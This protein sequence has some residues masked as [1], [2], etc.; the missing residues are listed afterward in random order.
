MRTWKIKVRYITSI[1]FTFSL[2]KQK[3]ELHADK[4]KRK[5]ETKTSSSYM[6]AH[7]CAPV[8]SFILQEPKS[9]TVTDKT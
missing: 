9:K 5:F 7:A 4:T 3:I 2:N 6:Y 1:N 8:E